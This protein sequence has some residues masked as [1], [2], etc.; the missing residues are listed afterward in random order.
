M[1]VH[2]YPIRRPRLTHEPIRISMLQRRP[3]ERFLAKHVSNPQSLAI[4]M[5]ISK[6]S[7]NTGLDFNG[8]F[9]LKDRLRLTKI[10]FQLFSSD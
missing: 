8:N 2:D 5:S 1:H 10:F 6:S 4:C 7:F 3:S 9:S